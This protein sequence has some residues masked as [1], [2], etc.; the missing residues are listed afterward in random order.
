MAGGVKLTGA[1]G[2]GPT[3]HGSKNQKHRANEGERA[4]TS[5]PRN[6]PEG[7]AGAADTMAGGM[8]LADVCG[9]GAKSH[10]TRNETHGE[11]EGTTASSPRAK[12]GGGDGSETTAT[13]T[14]RSVVG[15]APPCGSCGRDEAKTERGQQGA[16]EGGARLPFNEAEGNGRTRPR[17]ASWRR[18]LQRQERAVAEPRGVGDG[19]DRW[20]P[21]VSCWAR[22]L[23]GAARLGRHDAR[24]WA[25]GAKLGRAG[26]GWAGALAVVLGRGERNGHGAE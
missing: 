8:E 21:G 7:K 18:L 19:A 4:N 9:K 23:P 14:A 11:G 15:G 20:G 22:Q 6:R 25:A 1:R 2:K 3:A 5:M 17:R 12:I 13:R 26:K 24:G 16:R 10:E